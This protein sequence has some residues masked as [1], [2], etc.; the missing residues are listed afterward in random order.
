M[1]LYTLVNNFTA[2]LFMKK[3]EQT[4]ETRWRKIKFGLFPL[5]HPII[6]LIK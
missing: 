2:H 4:V 1:S 3:L 5:D 6:P